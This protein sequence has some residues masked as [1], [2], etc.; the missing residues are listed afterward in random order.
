MT[1]SAQ[2]VNFRHKDNDGMLV[3]TVSDDPDETQSSIVSV[4]GNIAP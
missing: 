2:V 1:K 4:G 3:I